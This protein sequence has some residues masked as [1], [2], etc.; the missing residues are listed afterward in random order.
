MS[1]VSNMVIKN[2]IKLFDRGDNEI[3]L[4]AREDKDR[5]E[6]VIEVRNKDFSY[7]LHIQFYPSSV[8]VTGVKKIYYSFGGIEEIK[9]L[10]VNPGMR[11]WNVLCKCEKCEEIE[12]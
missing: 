6:I 10:T 1:V 2:N 12:D 5:D 11:A 9:K 3:I 4:L 7:E 8:D